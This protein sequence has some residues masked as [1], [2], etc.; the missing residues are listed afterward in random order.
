M[1]RNLPAWPATGLL[2]GRSAL[3]SYIFI[4]NHANSVPIRRQLRGGTPT[5]GR[6]DTGSGKGAPAHGGRLRTPA[7][8]M[9]GDWRRGAG[10]SRIG[11]RGDH[12]FLAG[13][14]MT[15]IGSLVNQML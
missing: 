13:A 2:H 4:S 11:Q 9:G 6:W 12:F 1:S 14:M 15:S 5:V 8:G 10:R 3:Q 7:G